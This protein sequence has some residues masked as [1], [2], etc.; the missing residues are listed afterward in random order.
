MSLY[1]SKSISNF[2]ILKIFSEKITDEAL[3]TNDAY[4]SAR[5]AIT[6]EKDSSSDE[7]TGKTDQSQIDEGSSSTITGKPFL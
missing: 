7:S 6:N 5:S 3:S 2:T 1:I 4:T